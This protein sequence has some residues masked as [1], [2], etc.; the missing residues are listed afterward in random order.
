MENLL[1]IGDYAGMSYD[2]VVENIVCNYEVEQ[3]TVDQYKI[4]VAVLNS[5][6]YEEDAYFLL[7]HRATGK[8]YEIHAGHCS[9][10]GFE[11]QFS[12]EETTVEFIFSPHYT[13]RDD[14]AVMTYLANCLCFFFRKKK[15]QAIQKKADEV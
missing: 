5:G 15:L 12:P 8:L 6:S 14:Q 11:G 2:E 1:A 4:V 10:Y 9:C 7:L 13:Y 3:S